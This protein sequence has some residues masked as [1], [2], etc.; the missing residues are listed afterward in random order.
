MMNKMI[1]NNDVSLLW[2]IGLYQ[3]EASENGREWL[4]AGLSKEYLCVPGAFAPLFSLFSS[5]VLCFDQ[6]GGT[7]ELV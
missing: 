7:R 3:W 6:H 5:L 1:E 2:V 4:Q